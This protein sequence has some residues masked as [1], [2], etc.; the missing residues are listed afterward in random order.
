MGGDLMDVTISGAKDANRN[1]IIPPL[2]RHMSISIPASSRLPPAQDDVMAAYIRLLQRRDDEKDNE[3]AALKVE[4]AQ[5]KQHMQEVAPAT[6]RSA[7]DRRQRRQT[8][9]PPPLP[10]PQEQPYDTGYRGLMKDHLGFTPEKSDASELILYKQPTTF[11]TH[12][13]RSHHEQNRSRDTAGSFTSS[14]STSCVEFSGTTTE[15]P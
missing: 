10:P 9:P 5:M 2:E 1:L 7:G 12:R 14:Y 6:S 15:A 11:A 13:S 3:L 4:L 8:P